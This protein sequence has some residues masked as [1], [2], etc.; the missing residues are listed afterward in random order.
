MQPLTPHLAAAHERIAAAYS[1]DNFA[2]AGTKLI[3]TLADHLRRVESRAANVLNWNQPAELIR[4]AAASLA[5]GGQPFD[6]TNRIRDLAAQCLERGQNLHHPHYVGHQVPASVPLATLF[7]LIGSVTNQGMAIFEMGPFATAV[8]HAVVAAVGEQLG[9]PAGTFTGLVTSGGSLANLTA[10]LTARNVTLG[11]TWSAGL[12]DRRSGL[13][14]LPTWLPAPTTPN[15]AP[16][17]TLS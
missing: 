16:S 7:D 10:L 5:Q 15:A 2:A 3:E 6:V 1:P 13:A 14:P 8:E 11:D 17:S 4:E 12:A 9:F